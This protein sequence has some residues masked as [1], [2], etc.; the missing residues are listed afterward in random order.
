MNKNLTFVA[1]FLCGFAALGI[2]PVMAQ[3]TTGEE[4]EESGPTGLD[5][6]TEVGPEDQI[7]QLYVLE[8][9]G[10]WEIRC[11]RT[12]N[13]ENDPCQMNQTLTD[14][15]GNAVSEL[16]MFALPA[17]QAPAVAGA[18]I[19][20]PLMTQLTED[21][22]IT[23]DGGGERRY[24]FTVCDQEGCYARVGF[25]SEEIDSFKR[26]ASATLTIVPA[27]APDQKVVLDLSLTGFTAAYSALPVPAE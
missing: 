14:G 7:G 19:A 1:A 16:S 23:V 11:V 9:H 6:G 17:S 25:R 27:I 26:G 12:E 3:D 21:V 22:R 8:T 10:D 18:L 2:S 13:A 5:M 24:R 4:S 20:V 15:E